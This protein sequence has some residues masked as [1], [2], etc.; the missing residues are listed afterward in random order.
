MHKT[1]EYFSV[2]LFGGLALLLGVLLAVTTLRNI[3]RDRDLLMQNALTQGYWIA[4]SLE[5]GHSMIMQDHLKALRSLIIDLETQPDIHFLLVLDAQKQILLA[6]DTT[7]EGTRW[8]EDFGE[9]PE[10]GYMLTKRA[11]GTMEMVFPAFFAKTFSLLSLHHPHANDPLRHARW[12][13]LGL[14]ASE[15]HAHYRDIIIQSIFV[16]LGIV[17]LGLTAFWFFGMIQRYQLANASIAQLEQIKHHL[18]RFVPGVVQKLIEANPGHPT[19][20][21][22]EREVT[23]LFLDID[24]YTKISEQVTP[25]ALNALVETY[26]AAFLDVILSHGG[27]INETAG[28]GLMAVFTGKSPHEHALSAVRA[29]MR[30]HEQ[31]QTLNRGKILQ[32]PELLINIGINTGPVLLGATMIKGA[33]G[34]RFTYTAT[35]M[36][37]NIASRLCDLGSHGEIHLSE[38]T[39]HLVKD[40]ITL[41]GPCEVQMKNLQDPLAVYKLV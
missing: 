35:G 6:S 36:V 10:S 16:S 26:F 30:L 7:R 5:I 25:E 34:E 18:S 40:H 11:A 2:I 27:E 39:A 32:E 33:V 4:R 28:D 1:R 12:V 19:F 9:P 14:D 29:A 24:H 13:V 38:T 23:V 8:P 22:V 3:K 31:V 20:D 17:F 41:Q 15:A 21:K 37:T